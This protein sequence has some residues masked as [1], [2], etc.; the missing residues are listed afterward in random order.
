MNFFWFDFLDGFNMVGSHYVSMS[1]HDEYPCPCSACDEI[2][3]CEGEYCVMCLHHSCRFQEPRCPPAESSPKW[4]DFCWEKTETESIGQDHVCTS[5]REYATVPDSEI[6][7][8]LCEH[9]E[10]PVG[11]AP[12]IL[13]S[14]RLIETASEYTVDTALFHP[15]CY[16]KQKNIKH[17]KEVHLTLDTFTHTVL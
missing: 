8:T 13:P 5:C 10:S 2:S 1:V 11:E 7:Q 6:R 9:C 3:L 16:E 4:C 15:M 17:Q 12:W 14:G